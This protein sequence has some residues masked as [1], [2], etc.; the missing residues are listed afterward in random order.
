MRILS[1]QARPIKVEVFQM[2]LFD[3]NK[4]YNIAF[5]KKTVNFGIVTELTSSTFVLKFSEKL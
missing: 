2:S 4:T 1:R 5:L 3:L